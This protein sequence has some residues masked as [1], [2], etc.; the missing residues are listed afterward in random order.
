MPA[1]Q[2]KSCPRKYPLAKYNPSESWRLVA[3][4]SGQWPDVTVYWVV[5][6]YGLDDPCFQ[7]AVVYIKVAILG[8]IGYVL[9]FMLK[10]I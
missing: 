10:T 7:C 4:V 3:C 8:S 9:A 1:K 2:H 5:R 6:H